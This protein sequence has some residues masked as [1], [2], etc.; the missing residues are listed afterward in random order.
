MKR[1][2]FPPQG[3][4]FS[5]VLWVWTRNPRSLPEIACFLR[6]RRR[7]RASVIVTLVNDVVYVSFAPVLSTKKLAS[8]AS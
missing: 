3:G 6:R 4:H 5:Q 8:Y 1:F 2:T 7:R